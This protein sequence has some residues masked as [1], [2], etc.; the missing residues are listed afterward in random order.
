MDISGLSIDYTQERRRAALPAVN[1]ALFGGAALGFVLPGDFVDNPTEPVTTPYELFT[2]LE[3][4]PVLL[5]Q[6]LIMG[7]DAGFRD[8][9]Q[10]LA[11][12]CRVPCDQRALKLNLAPPVTYKDTFES[13]VRC[14]RDGARLVG[15]LSNAVDSVSLTLI[16]QG[17][18]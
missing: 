18:P 12:L 17:P 10:T 13:W 1:R 3:E 6:S 8:G 15:A 2:S 16:C 7:C 9:A 5:A 14:S 4:K 11:A